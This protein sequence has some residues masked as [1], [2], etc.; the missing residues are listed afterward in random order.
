M[1]ILYLIGTILKFLQGVCK[2][3]TEA[4]F[5]NKRSSKYYVKF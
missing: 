3:N 1:T 5:Q 2:V 4:K